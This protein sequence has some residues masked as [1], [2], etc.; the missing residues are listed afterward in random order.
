M[1]AMTCGDQ[2]LRIEDPPVSVLDVLGRHRVHVVNQEISMKIM[3]NNPK[4][5]TMITNDDFIPNHSPLSGTVEALVDPTIEAEGS[6]PHFSS[7]GQVLEALL[8]GVDAPEL[9]ITPNPRH[10]RPA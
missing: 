10:R 6:R 3:A 2:V 5:A 9:G 8:E 1:G 7:E 4:I